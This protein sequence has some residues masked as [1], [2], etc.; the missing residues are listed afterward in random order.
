[1]IL[2][3]CR[4]AACA[5]IACLGVPDPVS[6]PPPTYPSRDGPTTAFVPFKSRAIREVNFT[7]CTKSASMF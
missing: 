1:M 4:Q 7:H 6:P 3:L 2:L 5:A